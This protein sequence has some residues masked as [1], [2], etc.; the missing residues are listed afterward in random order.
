VAEGDRPA[1]VQRLVADALEARREFMA[2][3]DDIDPALMTA[4]GLVGEWSARELIAHLGYWCGHGAQALHQAAQGTLAEMDRDGP[5]VQE[6]N[7]TIARVARQTD[8][9]TVRK[10]EEGSFQAM[11]DLLSN[12]DPALLDQRIGYNATLESVLREDGPVHYRE[13]AEQLR[14][15]AETS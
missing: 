1:S 8:L 11:I 10:R 6:R 2:A 13:H 7:D 5:Q 9:A 3:L 15:R 12:A 14:T 4:P